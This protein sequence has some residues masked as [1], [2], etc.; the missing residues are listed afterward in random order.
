MTSFKLQSS[1]Y[2]FDKQTS[3]PLLL[4]IC[5]FGVLRR[6]QHST[7]HI[8]TGS[9]NGRGNQYIQ[10]ARV[11]YCKL[12]AN[13]KQLPAFPLMAM[14]GSNPGLSATVAPSVTIRISSK[15]FCLTLHLVIFLVLDNQIFLGLVC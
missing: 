15:T 3:T 13:G 14:T 7:G 1:H 2:H 9:W 11:L 6:F 8:T 12:P 5:L 10:F 4:F